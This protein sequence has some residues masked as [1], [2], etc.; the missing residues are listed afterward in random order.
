MCRCLNIP[1]A[2][3]YYKAIEPKSKAELEEMIKT[4]F[5]ES[6]SKGKNEAPIPNLL[7]RQFDYDNAVSE[8]TYRAFKL[9]FVNQENF[10]SLKE[11]I[12]KTKL[13]ESSSHS[14]QS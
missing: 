13:V 3:Y 1:R 4:I 7:A 8:S 11:L 9:E 5:R 2:S 12:L 6:N 10:H 14:Q